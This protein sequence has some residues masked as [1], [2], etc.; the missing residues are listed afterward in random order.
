[1]NPFRVYR[2]HFDILQVTIL[3]LCLHDN[4]LRINSQ[5]QQIMFDLIF[6]LFCSPASI[7][8]KQLNQFRIYVF[9]L[10][11]MRIWSDWTSFYFRIYKFYDAITIKEI[12][13]VLISPLCFY[14]TFPEVLCLIL[15]FLAFHS[16]HWGFCSA[17]SHLQ[18]QS[19]R[20]NKRF[21]HFWQHWKKMQV[22]YLSCLTRCWMKLL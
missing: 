15:H 16:A 14:R 19:L 8:F 21:H 12:I 10:G 18:T 17:S 5:A 20:K 11:H 2:V 13:P 4:F 22:S 7:V 1:M 6:I 3:S 9:Q